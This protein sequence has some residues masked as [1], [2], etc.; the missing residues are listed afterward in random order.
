MVGAIKKKGDTICKQ[1]WAFLLLRP[2]LSTL[3]SS[4]VA[5]A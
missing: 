4:F 1:L 5:L 3:L 2:L